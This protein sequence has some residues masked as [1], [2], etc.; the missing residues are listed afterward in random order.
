MALLGGL[1]AEA[2]LRLSG[3]R[4]FE[5]LVITLREG[6]EAALIVGIVLTFLQKTGRRRAFRA[7]YWALAGAVA[8]SLA[9]AYVVHRLELAEEAYEGWLMLAGGVFV[10]SMVVWMRK[11]GKSLRQDIETRLSTL[12]VE[13]ASS[14]T[15][16]VFLFVFLMVFREGIETVL[17]L[18]AVTARAADSAHV[19][20]LVGAVA[21]L[22][23]AVLLGAAF[24]KGSF[25]IDLQKFFSITSAVLLVIAAQLLITGVHE[26]SEG[27]YLPS[28]Q[29]EMALIGPVVHNDVLFFVIVIALCLLL[30][31]ADRT[32]LAE[33]AL[34]NLT[35]PLRRKA[36]AEWRRQR[37]W[38]LAAASAGVMV[39]TLVTAQ[40]VY[41][42]QAEA[43]IPHVTVVPVDGVVRIPTSA[44]AD[45]RLHIYSVPTPDGT[46]RL[47]AFLDD[48]DTVRAA[49]DACQVCGAQGYYQEG[50]NIICR[51]CGAAIVIQSIGTAGGCNPIPIQF[52]VEGNA[53]TISESGLLP[54]ARIFQ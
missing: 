44:L 28:N 52:V 29:R 1:G 38:K 15:M 33:S 26:L 8:A 18:A 16:G 25:K 21:G 13:R 31:V 17:F 54:S 24:F 11:A 22:A 48:K 39:V 35:A 20:S 5:S 7:V 30:L 42:R 23:L 51:N 36:R 45:H 47:M 10:A 19:L 27:G 37:R 6:V 53:L 3:E 46:V 4:V 32:K 43:P 9:A 49:L 50:R 12:S 41:S 34:R 40:F 2:R 14:A